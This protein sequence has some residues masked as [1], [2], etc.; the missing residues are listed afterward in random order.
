[1]MAVYLGIDWS[2]KSHALVFLN[3]TGGVIAQESIRHSS[4][5]LGRLDQI[6][7]EL[8]VEADRCVVG[9]ETAHHLMIDWLWGHGYKQV[10]VIPPTVT[11]SR[12]AT[13]RQSGARSDGH[14]AYLIA[15]LLRTDRHLLHPWQPD[16]G[17]TQHLRSQVDLRRELVRVRLREQS[18]LRAVL[19]RYHPA[20]LEAF[21]LDSG[22]CL[23]FLQRYPTPAALTALTW[24][25]FRQ[26][27]QE[28]GYKNQYW[29]KAFAALTAPY[30]QP[31]PCVVAAH[32]ASALVLAQRL[33]QTRTTLADVETTIRTLFQQHPDAPIYASLPGTGPVLQ[34]ALLAK[35][36]VS[37]ARFP[38]AAVLQAL[39]GTCP[40]TVQSGGRRYVTFRRAC[41]RE[42]RTI[43]Q[44][45][46]RLS[47]THSPWAVGYYTQARERGLSLSHTYRALANRWLAILWTL[48]QSGQP[49][50][51]M[52]H[53]LRVQQRA[54]PRR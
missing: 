22:V 12:Q 15:N 5:G 24:D 18:Q 13:Y 37:R 29:A 40:V 44:Q 53:L 27:A 38:T 30:P 52:R 7:R 9:I 20:P 17:L 32:Q 19:M 28:V 1:M 41:D 35:L 31:L 54:R 51:E 8:A 16:D 43:A 33:S 23:A 47:V 26:F 42:F 48:W 25:E 39:A 34:P 6:R 4:Q 49:Y 36:G 14:D 3:E 45:W 10:Y 50:D 21:S 11:R 2:E 46:A